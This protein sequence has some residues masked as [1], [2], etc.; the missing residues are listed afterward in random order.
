MLH[1]NTRTCAS[2]QVLHVCFCASAACA[3]AHD[4]FTCGCVLLPI[5]NVCA[6]MQC[7]SMPLSLPES[8]ALHTS[9][10]ANSHSLQGQWIPR[11]VFHWDRVCVD[12]SRGTASSF[13]TTVGR[14]GNIQ[15]LPDRECPLSLSTSI[16]I[17]ISPYYYA[18]TII[19]LLLILY[20]DTHS[21]ICLP[22]SLH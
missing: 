10:C 9:Q 20:L 8:L 19:F 17:L 15:A 22:L 14:F 6:C 13:A 16:S 1:M 2:V 12:R 21:I 4:V 18:L 11:Y 5:Q 3:H 7:R